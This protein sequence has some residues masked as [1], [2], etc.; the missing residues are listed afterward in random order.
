MI[1]SQE[2]SSIMELLQKLQSYFPWAEPKLLHVLSEEALF[3]EVA[4]GSTLLTEGAWVSSL[5]FVL[6]GRVKVMSKS[7]KRE[8]LLYYLLPG[9]SCIM[10]FS[11]SLQQHPS[12]IYA[13]AEEE[14][15]LLLIPVEKLS[16]WMRHFPSLSR[17]I[18]QLYDRRYLDLLD[19]VDQLIFW[20]LEDRL[21]NYLKEQ[22]RLN[23]GAA[24][25]LT[26]QQI[27]LDLGS[28]REVISRIL[29]KLVREGAINISRQEIS[30]N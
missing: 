10:S 11:A 5:P 4:E 13:V 26:H 2:E 19:T 9:E 20:K 30:V 1:P 25:Q 7:E 29:K 6:K 21:L 15:E 17:F 27:A 12:R 3:A 22:Q 28:A 24:V 14:S 18:F 16:L 8:L 23:Q